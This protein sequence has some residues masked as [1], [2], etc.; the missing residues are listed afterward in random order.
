MSSYAGLNGRAACLCYPTE[1]THGYEITTLS[2]LENCVTLLAEYFT[3]AKV[4]GTDAGAAP[5]SASG[6]TGP[7]RRKR[8][9]G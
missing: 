6:E 8:P 7:G 3:H 5:V 2:A 1:N 9:R 4:Q